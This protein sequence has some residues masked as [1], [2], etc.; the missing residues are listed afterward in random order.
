[1]SFS[2][3]LAAWFSLI[4]F[5]IELL[6][7]FEACFSSKLFLLSM[8]ENHVGKILK[9]NIRKKYWRKSCRKSIEENHVEKV[10][11]KNIRKKYWRKSWRKSIEE[12]HVEKVLKKNI[13]KKYW[14]KSCRKS[15]EEN[16]EEKILKKT[17]QY[18]E[19]HDFV[20]Y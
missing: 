6:N 18:F 15:I 4:L 9:K 13:R 17:F 5:P 7:D 3:L 1:M 11:K 10:L 2:I 8:E 12:N 20:Q 19:Q 16:H 14:R